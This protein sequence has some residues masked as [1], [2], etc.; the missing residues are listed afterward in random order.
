MMLFKSWK[1][2]QLLMFISVVTIIIVLTL[3]AVLMNYA[4]KMILNDYLQSLNK[5]NLEQVLNNIE[6]SFDDMKKIVRTIADDPKLSFYAGNVK[7]Y[8]KSGITYDIIKSANAFSKYLMMKKLIYGNIQNIIY[9]NQSLLIQSN[10]AAMYASKQFSNAVFSRLNDMGE[11]MVVTIDAYN[12]EN[13][14]I[15]KYLEGNLN[16]RIDDTIRGKYHGRTIFICA[17]GDGFII[18]VMSNGWLRDSVQGDKNIV[19]STV[20]GIV[21]YSINR[22]MEELYEKLAFDIVNPFECVTKRQDN[23]SYTVSILNTPQYRVALLEDMTPI[24]SE[25]EQTGYISVILVIILIIICAFL[26]R[27]LIGR[28][29]RDYKD[30]YNMVSAYPNEKDISLPKRPAKSIRR[31][32]VLYFSLVI[33]IPVI[34][35]S[36]ILMFRFTDILQKN[37]IERNTNFLHKQMFFIENFKNIKNKLVFSIVTNDET[38]N[39]LSDEKNSKQYSVFNDNSHIYNDVSSINIYSKDRELRFF[40]SYYY[41]KDTLFG[42]QADNRWYFNETNRLSSGMFRFVS[43]ITQM[44]DDRLLLEPIGYVEVVFQNTLLY[45][46]LQKAQQMG[47]DCF[48]ATTSGMVVAHQNSSEIGSVVELDKSTMMIV[49]SQDIPLL[50]VVKEVNLYISQTFTSFLIIE[51]LIIVMVILFGFIFS[52]VVSA[53]IE[54]N[55]NRMLLQLESIGRG[56]FDST[57]IAS[58]IYELDRLYNAFESMSQRIKQLIQDE[59]ASKLREERLLN[60]RNQC[61]LTALQAQIN[62]HFLFNTLE[63]VKWLMHG[64]DKQKCETLVGDLG[65]LLRYSVKIGYPLVKISEELHSAQNY[66]DIQKVRLDFPIDVLF[67]LDN[68]LLNCQTIRMSIQPLIENSIIH[69]FITKEYPGMISIKLYR[70]GEEVIISISDNGYGIPCDKLLEIQENLQ[71]NSI[72]EHIGIYNVNKRLKLYF[73]EQ[74]GVLIQSEQGAGTTVFLKQPYIIN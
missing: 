64:G 11:V 41:S 66:L 14:D 1:T 68:S 52:W 73:G 49:P 12:S 45:P 15:L 20:D 36:A 19:I 26:T 74:C 24:D 28:L 67:Y 70:E 42:D 60:E 71:K 54:R 56:R 46:L 31:L 39:L 59:Y 61:E 2:R 7:T 47:I 18:A 62:P 63:S 9:E 57:K 21:L 30:F 29:F 50:V 40:T 10:S 17:S 22:S 37:M 58:N 65:K 51:S 6:I 4:V 53:V 55:L 23:K 34:I 16:L 48:L 38:R 33:F 35:F 43:P 32:L 3:D 44:K 69:G 27:F 13:D 25:I 5:G 8:E 72:D